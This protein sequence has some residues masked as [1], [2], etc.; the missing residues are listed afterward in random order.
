MGKGYSERHGGPKG[1]ILT[2]HEIK[3]AFWMQSATV[4]ALLTQFVEKGIL[5]DEDITAINRRRD[6]LVQALARQDA[7]GSP[8]LIRPA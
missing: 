8:K 2:N 6:H 3:T 5:T 4:S 1:A 7:G